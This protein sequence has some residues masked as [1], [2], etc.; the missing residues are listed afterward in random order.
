MSPLAAI[1]FI[2]EFAFCLGTYSSL[3]PVFHRRPLFEDSDDSDDL[4]DSIGKPFVGPILSMM[5]RSFPM[6]HRIPSKSWMPSLRRGIT[7]LG[8][9]AEFS[10]SGINMRGMSPFHKRMGR[11]RTRIGKRYNKRKGL[12]TGNY[13]L[14]YFNKMGTKLAGGIVPFKLP[15]KYS[16]VLATGF[17]GTPNLRVRF[18]DDDDD[19]KERVSTDFS[20]FRGKVESDDNKFAYWMGTSTPG[21]WGQQAQ[22]IIAQNIPNEEFKKL[23]N[24][25]DDRFENQAAFGMHSHSTYMPSKQPQLQSSF[26]Q[27][28]LGGLKPQLPFAN[29][30]SFPQGSIRQGSNP[31][32]LNPKT[33]DD[34]GERIHAKI[35]DNNLNNK[36]TFNTAFLA[37]NPSGNFAEHSDSSFAA[38]ASGSFA[39]QTNGHLDSHHVGDTRR[40]MVTGVVQSQDFANFNPKMHTTAVVASSSN[41]RGF[42]P[43]HQTS[44]FKENHW[45]PLLPSSSSALR[46]SVREPRL[47]GQRETHIEIKKVD[48]DSTERINYVAPRSSSGFR[49]IPH[50]TSVFHEVPTAHDNPNV[51][52]IGSKN[53]SAEKHDQVSNNGHFQAGPIDGLQLLGKSNWQDLMNERANAAAGGFS[54]FSDQTLQDLHVLQTNPFAGDAR[55]T[56]RSPG[57]T[58]WNH[59]SLS[60]HDP[61]SQG[62][63][64]GNTNQGQHIDFGMNDRNGFSNFN[65]HSVA[66]AVGLGSNSFHTDSHHTQNTA[67]PFPHD[68]SSPVVDLT[69][70]S[71]PQSDNLM[72]NFDGFIN[73][74]DRFPDQTEDQPH[75]RLGIDPRTFEALQPRTTQKKIETDSDEAPVHPPPIF[76]AQVPEAPVSPESSAGVAGAHNGASIVH[77]SNQ[78]TLVEEALLADIGKMIALKSKD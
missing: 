41:V 39:G 62:T 16:P 20:G 4:F 42:D 57:F 61:T 75:T 1:V 13:P 31:F 65:D 74:F 28:G 19:S 14:K 56:A 66:S 12:P 25:F 64:S 52:D 27:P 54:T 38:H 78:Q 68:I 15:G 73:I 58:L 71:Q 76:P 8:N 51:H 53:T 9:G 7:S 43:F 55:N 24:T 22:P 2:V 37:G 10:G 63:V 48:N 67:L 3:S 36:H 59:H 21:S 35:E 77:T 47:I 32:Q 40:S 6:S 5:P 17:R 18:D 69:S 29:T 34:M 70:S 23:D 11:S 49:P 60:N 50:A 33:F 45:S 44:T 30:P 72:T 26:I 46:S